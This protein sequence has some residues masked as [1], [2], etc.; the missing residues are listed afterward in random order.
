MFPNLMVNSSGLA[1]CLLERNYRRNVVGVLVLGNIGTNEAK[2]ISYE[3]SST[4]LIRI[5]LLKP[6]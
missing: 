5:Y 2:Q 1:L 6:L 3:L 4:L